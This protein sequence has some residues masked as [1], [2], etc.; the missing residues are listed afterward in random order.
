MEILSFL[1][2]T[3]LLLLFLLLFTVGGLGAVEIVWNGGSGSYSDQTKWSMQSVPVGADNVYIN[4]SNSRV[5]IN[6]Q[7]QVST[8]TISR[9]S[10]LD[11]NG[12]L[13]A[14][15]E[16]NVD[17]ST[18]YFNPATGP[19]LYGSSSS[20]TLLD[21][22]MTVNTTNVQF[23]GSMRFFENSL[24]QT[25]QSNVTSQ[26][27]MEF[28]NN[29]T[30]AISKSSLNIIGNNVPIYMYSSSG[31]L[32]YV[33][34][35]LFSVDVQ[36]SFLLISGARIFNVDK[37]SQASIPSFS[38]TN[39]TITITNSDLNII[40]LVK[41]TNSSVGLKTSTLNFNDTTTTLNILGR[42]TLSG[43]VNSNFNFNSNVPIN[44]E[45]DS[46]IQILVGS[47]LNA[48]Q[49][50][51]SIMN[52]RVG[53]DTQSSI[54]IQNLV[55]NN[56]N[57]G[58]KYLST[59]NIIGGLSNNIY[60]S[61]NFVFSQSSFNINNA[62]FV[63]FANSSIL[64]L[65]Q[66]KII[67]NQ[68][69]KLSFTDTSSIQSL[70]SKITSNGQFDINDLED[71]GSVFELNGSSKIKGQFSSTSGTI[72]VNGTL[73]MD[74]ATSSLVMSGDSPSITVSA[75]SVI[76]GVSGNLQ[77]TTF[78]NQGGEIKFSPFN[79]LEMNNNGQL[80]STNGTLVFYLNDINN[81]TNIL[82]V[83]K[84]ILNSTRVILM[85]NRNLLSGSNDIVVVNY[86]QLQGN[87][88]VEAMQYDEEN[89][90]NVENG[91][92]S[93]YQGYSIDS[94]CNVRSAFDSFSLTVSFDCVSEKAMLSAGAI[95]GIV[96]GAAVF[97]GLVAMSILYH[98]EIIGFFEKQKRIVSNN[99]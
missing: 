19:F 37:R 65:T 49:S 66:T 55:A 74:P 16:I 26:N 78:T 28:K 68:S 36:N 59:L 21:S 30:F 86:E 39:S 2:K 50:K 7:Y 56:G 6:G 18:V 64:N 4:T 76:S 75:G 10:Q 53:A 38:S 9:N 80:S 79:K 34:S 93:T 71:T 51:L 43:L 91:D 45:N 54:N 11:M 3:L 27:E 41:L 13:T 77:N 47:S 31:V 89:I 95:A 63:H 57:V 40:N 1:N 98:K 83:N 48:N 88:T 44:V 35:S 72:K 24:F 84:L 14:Q 12:N 8:L 61:S 20:S 90:I 62:S 22:T 23:S 97:V 42:S 5:L 46:E 92:I 81:A 25:T 69:C 96:I 15:Q 85:I 87:T 29:A 58:I 82:N 32:Q 52:S 73:A 17:N 33:Q 94:D 99:Q 70:N 60:G 67:I